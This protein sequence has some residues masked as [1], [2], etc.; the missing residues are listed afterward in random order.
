MSSAVAIVGTFFGSFD[1]SSAC[2]M[3]C[4]ERTFRLAKRSP[5]FSSMVIVSAETAVSPCHNRD[6]P[7]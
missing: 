7:V 4:V 2:C 5:V 1:C 3:T 6:E